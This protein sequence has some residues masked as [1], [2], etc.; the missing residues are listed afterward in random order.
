MHPPEQTAPPRVAPPPP[1]PSPAGVP[2]LFS[3]AFLADPYPTYAMLREMSPVHRIATPQGFDMW[4]L[5]RYEDVRRAVTDPRFS[6]N[7]RLAPPEAT[8]LTGDPESPVNRNLLTLDPPDHTRVRSL[9]QSAFTGRRVRELTGRVETVLDGLLSTA[10]RD[11][12]IDLIA[13]VAYPLPITL[14]CELLG[15]PVT[16]RDD[17][18]E[19]TSGLVSTAGTDSLRLLRQSQEEL[20]AYFLDLVQR[21]RERPG[22]DLLSALVAVRDGEARLSE[23]E[24]VGMAFMLLVAGHETT[25][26]LIATG[27]QLLLT[28][29]AERAAVAADPT[30]LEPAIDEILRFDGP[31][32]IAFMVAA[33]EVELPGG[34]VPRGAVTA[35][36]WH[37][38]NRDPER[39]ADPDVFRVRRGERGHLG[40][41]HGV[42]RCI[43]APL[44]RMETRIALREILRRFPRARVAVPPGQLRWRQAPFFR[45][46]E[47]L[48]VVLDP[49]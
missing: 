39:F 5:T 46:L 6:R 33:E 12:P 32:G 35:A 17:F 4:L 36:L 14:I 18:R 8:A 42:H 43:G 23:S 47:E 29:P 22:E 40:F 20:L 1:G 21:K 27:T 34:T 26:N 25:V 15:V 48:P 37:A 13:S 49:G 9:V 11:E 7:L 41:G 44:A 28:H 19:W 45:G 2:P 16:D 30:L 3:P 31:A 10:P 24:L 38:A